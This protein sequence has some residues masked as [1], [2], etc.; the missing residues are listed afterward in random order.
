LL[1]RGLDALRDHFQRVYAQE[2]GDVTITRDKE[3]DRLS[4][5]VHSCPAVSHI[6]AGGDPVSGLFALTHS[7]IN[8][9]LCQNTPY[10]AELIDYQPS[11]GACLQV[12]ARKEHP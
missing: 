6:R 2:G 8:A 1:E 11:D 7:V 9:S 3:A 12:F 5:R 4:I 10:R